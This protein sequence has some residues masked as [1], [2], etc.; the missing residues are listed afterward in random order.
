MRSV[1]CDLVALVGTETVQLAPRLGIGGIVPYNPFPIGE[2]LR[3]QR[4]PCAGKGFL[5]SVVCW[6]NNRDHW[7]TFIMLLTLYR[8]FFDALLLCE[9]FPVY[10]QA[11]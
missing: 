6:R 2:R 4:A 3:P 11:P 5:M 8:S 7:I 1:H 10:V 9:L